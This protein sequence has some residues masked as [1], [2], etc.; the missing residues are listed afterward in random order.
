[1]N[2]TIFGGLAM[3]AGFIM[4]SMMT[5]TFS[6]REIIN[7]TDAIYEHSL[8]LPAMILLLIGAFTKS[9]QFPFS[10]W[11]AGCNGSSNAN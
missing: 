2:I 11:S 10:I 3:L 9:A 4:L 5:E 6:I 1:M 7:Q 8:F